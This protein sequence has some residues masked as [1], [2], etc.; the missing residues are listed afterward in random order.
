LSEMVL[1]THKSFVVSYPAGKCAHCTRDNLVHSR[2]TAT[3]TFF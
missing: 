3:S 1:E 2:Y